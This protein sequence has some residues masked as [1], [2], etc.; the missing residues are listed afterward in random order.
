VTPLAL[1]LVLLAA[2]IH[3]AWNLLAKRSGG[4]A[5]FIFLSFVMSTAVYAPVA[6][7]VFA[8]HPASFDAADLLFI[9]GNGL[10]HAGYFLLLQRGYRA[11]DLSLVYPLARGTGPLL[12]SIAAIVFLG[13]RPSIVATAGILAIVAGVFFA[14]GLHRAPEAKTRLSLAYGIATGV[15]IAAYT[16]WDKHAMSALALSPILYDWGGNVART[17]TMLPWA[18]KSGEEVKAAWHTVRWDA[19][20]V[21][22]LSPLAYI[23]ILWALTWTP[24]TDVAPAREV[25]IMFGTLFGIAILKEREH[26][27]RRILAAC[28]MLGGVAALARS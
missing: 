19:L 22:V 28:L 1:T 9:A 21:A 11:G 15:S 17:L 23:M 26:M 20:G 12:A 13:E 24:V 3:A 4:G 27:P 14:S 6:A 5:G 7:L 2:A 10:L 8:L 16:L 18:L 25:S